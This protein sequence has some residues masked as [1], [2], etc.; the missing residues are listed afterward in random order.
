MPPHIRY[1]VNLNL[2]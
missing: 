1:K 2:L